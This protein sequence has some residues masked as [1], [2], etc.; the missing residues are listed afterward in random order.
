MPNEREERS[1][2]EN[3]RFDV[4]AEQGNVQQRNAGA[5]VNELPQSLHMISEIECPVFEIGPARV[6]GPGTNDKEKGGRENRD[7]LPGIG[8][9]SVR[10]RDISPPD[11]I[12]SCW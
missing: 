12:A 7:R 10:H 2:K 8:G 11:N 5:P 6:G 9:G 3:D 1:E 4:V